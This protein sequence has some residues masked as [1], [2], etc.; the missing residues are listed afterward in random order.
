MYY[1]WD[2]EAA[3][4]EF[5]RAVQTKPNYVTAHH[6][7]A[8]Y[9]TWMGRHEEAIAEITRAHELDPLSPLI[10]YIKAYLLFYARQYESSLE[11]CRQTLELDP[12]FTMA[13]HGI[14]KFYIQKGKYD[15]AIL[16]LQ[17]SKAMTYLG[18]AYGLAGKRKEALGIAKEMEEQWRQGNGRA[19]SI[20][21]V[22]V[23]LGEQDLALD[24]LEKSFEIREPR[25]AE[26]K[27]DPVFDSLR[28]HPRFKAL[29]KK[30]KL[31]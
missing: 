28:S 17:K 27:V 12:N 4:A 2:W 15:E 10:N 24:W 18:L 30:M 14:G 23:G 25:M 7:Y 9:L 22:Y 13:Y 29:L 21:R 19:F 11:Q 31:E 16:E 20:I 5:K 8:E 3:E 1:D 26:I 6:W